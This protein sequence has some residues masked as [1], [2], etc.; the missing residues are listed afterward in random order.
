MALFAPSR[1]CGITL[2]QSGDIEVALIGHFTPVAVITRPL[3]VALTQNVNKTENFRH[4][5]R[6]SPVIPF[7]FK[8]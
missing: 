4:K 8:H 6:I 1:C 2:R 5:G 3:P 7:Q